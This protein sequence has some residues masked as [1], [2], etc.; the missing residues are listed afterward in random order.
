MRQESHVPLQFL[1]GVSHGRRLMLQTLIIFP[2]ITC[3]H[4]F[5]EQELAFF[6]VGLTNELI[7][8]FKNNLGGI[9][10]FTPIANNRYCKIQLI[11]L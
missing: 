10:E 4:Y 6:L 2:E 1:P 11:P 3:H 9:E 7:C 5:V 8:Y